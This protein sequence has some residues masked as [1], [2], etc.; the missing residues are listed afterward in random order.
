MIEYRSAVGILSLRGWICLREQVWLD[1][2]ILSDKIRGD[3]KEVLRLVKSQ[4]S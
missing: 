3:I 1:I 2:V 4:N